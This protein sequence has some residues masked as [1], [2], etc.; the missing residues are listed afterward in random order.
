MELRLGRQ[1]AGYQG[2]GIQ[3][4]SRPQT[5]VPVDKSLTILGLLSFTS[6]WGQGL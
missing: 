4:R 3:F 6:P 2:A 5:K 1:E